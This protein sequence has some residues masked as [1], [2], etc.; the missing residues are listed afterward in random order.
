MHHLHGKFCG[1]PL[2]CC[3]DMAIQ[4]FSKWRLLL[5]LDFKNFE[6][7]MAFHIGN[8]LSKAT[9]KQHRQRF[10]RSQAAQ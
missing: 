4:P 2:N 9:C 5:I 7:L 1:D 10:I 8:K 6:I 3:Q